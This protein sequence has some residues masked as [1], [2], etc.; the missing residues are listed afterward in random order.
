MPP[1]IIIESLMSRRIP[2]RFGFSLQRHAPPTT[3]PITAMAASVRQPIIHLAFRESAMQNSSVRHMQ[4][5]AP[6]SPHGPT[7]L[8]AA[9]IRVISAA[10]RTNTESRASADAITRTGHS[11]DTE[12]H[13]LRTALFFRRNG[14]EPLR[15]H[16]RASSGVSTSDHHGTAAMGAIHYGWRANPRQRYKLSL[17]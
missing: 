10:D 5:R 8:P 3:V 4:F 2:W 7:H 14:F 12:Y 16:S 17:L 11:C 13:M 1:G 9:E 6:N 15:G